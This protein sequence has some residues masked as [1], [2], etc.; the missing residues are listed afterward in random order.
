MSESQK[1]ALYAVITV[2]V[3]I[4]LF[5]P[6]GNLGWDEAKRVVALLLLAIAVGGIVWRLLKKKKY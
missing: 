5:R 3:L 1:N 6:F 4:I 2:I